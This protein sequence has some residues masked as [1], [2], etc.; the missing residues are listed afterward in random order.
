M[1]QIFLFLIVFFICSLQISFGVCEYLKVPMKIM[2]YNT[3]CHVCDLR[4]EN[5]GSY[6]DRMKNLQDV[7]NRNQPDIMG[8]QELFFKN[9]VKEF[10][11]NG[12]TALY[13]DKSMPLLGYDADACIVFNNTRFSVKD[14]GFY[15]LGRHDKVPIDFDPARTPR[16]A[17]W[18][19]MVDH[20]NNDFQFFFGTTHFDHGDHYHKESIFDSTN[21]AKMAPDLLDHTQPYHEQGLPVIYTGDFNSNYNS[22]AYDI[23]TN[24][25]NSHN[26]GYVF[27]ETWDL[28]KKVVITANTEPVPEYDHTSSIDHIFVSASDDVVVSEVSVDTY[29]Y[30]Y[31]T[32]DGKNHSSNPSDHKAIFATL[33]TFGAANSNQY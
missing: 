30:P 24:A 13:N 8:V 15:F 29:V 10:T 32:K 1:G 20:A 9:D 11:P 12:F 28:A 18:A 21:C 31:A 3:D 2:S 23:L 17:Q 14:S 22:N 33:T 19:L 27:K 16:E 5:G 7:V 4:H 6:K 26:Q 25:S